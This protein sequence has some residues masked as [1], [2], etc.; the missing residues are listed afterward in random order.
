[1]PYR[2]LHHAIRQSSEIRALYVLLFV[3]F[4]RTWRRLQRK[5]NSLPNI[6]EV[7]DSIQRRFNVWFTY[8]LYNNAHWI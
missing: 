4:L 3:I 8:Y 6:I 5:W 2:R 1:M 7:I